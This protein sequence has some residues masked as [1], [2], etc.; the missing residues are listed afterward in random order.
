V[1]ELKLRHAKVRAFGMTRRRGVK[2]EDDVGM[3]RLLAAQTPVITFVGKTS[4]Y[5]VQDVMSVSLEENL[6]MIGDSVR[7]MRAAG[8]QSRLRRRAF[9]D[10]VPEATANTRSR[11]LLAAQEP[12]R[13][14][15]A[16]CD[17][18]RRIH[19]R[20]SSRKPSPPVRKETSVKFGFHTHNDAGVGDRERV[21]P[22]FASG[23]GSP[24]R[25]RST[26]SASG[27]QHGPPP[28]HR[29]TSGSQVQPSTPA[30]STSS[31]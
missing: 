14:L 1:R 12:A 23:C 29:P 30:A 18:I 15:L 13:G 19:A 2:A 26:A 21:R 20:G 11:L 9:F 31:T 5:Q 28:A 4:D 27:R 6:K 7:L 16:L 10:T 25:A 8:R 24:P 17:T 3:K 22:A